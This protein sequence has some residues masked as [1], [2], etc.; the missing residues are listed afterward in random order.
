MKKLLVITAIIMLL[1]IHTK[2]ETIIIPENAIRYRVVASSNSANDQMVKNKV[3]TYMQEYLINLTSSAKSSEEAST[4]LLNNHTN[5]ENYLDKFMRQNNYNTT[6]EVNIGRNYFPNKSYK[7]VDY[8]E[9]YYDS[10]VINLG[11]KQGLNWW[12]VM[13]PPLCLMDT[14]EDLNEVEYTT[15]AKEILNKYN[16]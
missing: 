6:Y 12:C 14:K 3:S 10:I 13:Y 7:G 8:P 11:H 5:I 9:G 15:F 2:E 4:I 1:L 16:I